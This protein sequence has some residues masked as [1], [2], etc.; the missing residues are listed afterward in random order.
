M[1]DLT[2][3][4]LRFMRS[5][6]NPAGIQ[7]FL[8]S[9]P[10]HVANTAW[11]PRLV[12]KNQTAHCLEGA[13]F[14]AAT[15]RVLGFPPLIVDLEAVN[16][17]DHVI[18]VFKQNGGWGAIASSNYATCRF[19]SPVYKTLRELTL[20]YFEGYFNLRAERTLRT[21]STKPINMSR[22]D[23]HNWTTSEKPL[24][25]IADYLF[26]VPHTRLLSPAMEK[27]LLRVD[28]RSFNAGRTGYKK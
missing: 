5:L 12:I 6:K 27:N 22:F 15:L 25:Y 13:F 4:E 21:F 17:T 2:P 3:A 23:R 28:E 19:R 9:I 24:W 18:A 7:K 14:A 26:D 16:D 11:S 10:Y 1:Q 20:S 8:D